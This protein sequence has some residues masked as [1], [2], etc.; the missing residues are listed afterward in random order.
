MYRYMFL[1]SRYILYRVSEITRRKANVFKFDEFI[2][3]M[4]VVKSFSTP[5]YYV[6][7]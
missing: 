1:K 6:Y 5:S 2:K 7:E 3:L 4:I